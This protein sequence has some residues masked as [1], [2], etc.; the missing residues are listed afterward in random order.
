MAHPC[1]MSLKPVTGEKRFL[2]HPIRG[3]AAGKP[4]TIGLTHRRNQGE[5]ERGTPPLIEIGQPGV[6]GL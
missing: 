3:C 6:L 2:A 5:R 1:V 4:R